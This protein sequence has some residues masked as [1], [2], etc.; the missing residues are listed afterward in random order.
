MPDHRLGR[1]HRQF[2]GVLAE[3]PMQRLGFGHVVGGRAGAVGVD[4]LNILRLQFAVV[5]RAFHGAAHAAEIGR[6]E[7]GGIRAHAEADDLTE[8]FCAARARPLQRLQHQHG[9]ALAEY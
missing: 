6:R 7:I 3:H 1:R 8:D 9:G 5:E 4:V 2:A